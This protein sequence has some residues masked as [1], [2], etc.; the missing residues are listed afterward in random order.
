M[1]RRGSK[2]EAWKKIARERMEI[3]FEEADKA[4]DGHPGRSRRYVGLALKIGMRYNVRLPPGRKRWFCRKCS[5]YLKPGA[6][7]RVRTS[8]E[9]QAVVITCLSCGNVS[10]YPYIREKETIKKR[11]KG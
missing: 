1:G 2:P 3:L 4:F 5:S 10:R 11:E 6:S 9:K 7:C 8:R